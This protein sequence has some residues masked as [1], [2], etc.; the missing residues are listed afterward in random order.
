MQ[1]PG[2]SASQLLPYSGSSSQLTLD[3]VNP[4]GMRPRHRKRKRHVK[5]R[6]RDDPGRD[7]KQQLKSSYLW[8]GRRRGDEGRGRGK[9]RLYSTQAEGIGR[10]QCR[11]KQASQKQ[12]K[13]KKKKKYPRPGPWTGSPK[14]EDAESE[15]V[16][17]IHDSA[18]VGSPGSAVRDNPMATH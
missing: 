16:R 7:P 11:V 12:K 17:V 6:T 14:P 9:L 3:H 8:R 1:L 15:G 5:E 4:P 2:L 13:R 18:G 10:G